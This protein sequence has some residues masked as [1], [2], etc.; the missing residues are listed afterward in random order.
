MDAK[1]PKSYSFYTKL[2]IYEFSYVLY[3]FLETETSAIIFMGRDQ[4]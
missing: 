3:E 4:S 2:Y 1:R